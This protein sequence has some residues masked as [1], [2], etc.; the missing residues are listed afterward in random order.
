MEAEARKNQEKEWKQLRRQLAQEERIKRVEANEICRQLRSE[1]ERLL[2]QYG[3]KA[4]TNLRDKTLTAIV[5]LATMPSAI[6]IYRVT[7][8]QA[9]SK[10]ELKTELNGNVEDAVEVRITSSNAVPKKS[11]DIR[12]YVQGIPQYL[13][14]YKDG[15]GVIRGR[16][17]DIFDKNATP[18]EAR[19]YRE[20]LG[21]V[22][23]NFE[24]AMQPSQP[25]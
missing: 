13:S 12:I 24:P 21:K 6:L 19:K 25:H 17:T 16:R 23:E 20:L 8:L 7:P 4:P 3:T 2:N 15:T 18:D 22:K 9:L 5:G 10:K 14:L 11:Q 1:S